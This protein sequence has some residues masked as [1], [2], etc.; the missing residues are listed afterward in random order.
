[1]C[2]GVALYLLGH[3]AFRLRLVGVVSV[4]EIVTAAAV[5]VLYFAGSA[6]RAWALASAV[7]ALLTG[8][9]LLEGLLERRGAAA[10]IS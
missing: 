7:A 2:G 10:E 9:C 3:C 5:M 8:L 4:E 1:M 6:M